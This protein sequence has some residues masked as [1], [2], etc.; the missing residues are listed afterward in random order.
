L[1]SQIPSTREHLQLYN[2]VDIGL[3][4]FP[5]NGTTTTCEALWMGVPVVVLD[6]D[7]HSG[8][9]GVSLLTRVGLTELIADSGADY[10]AKAV[11][12]AQDHQRLAQLRSG[13]R[14]RMQNSPLCD[15]QGFAREVEKSYRKMWQ[16]WCQDN[17]IDEQKHPFSAR[18]AIKKDARKVLISHHWGVSQIPAERFGDDF[19][20]VSHDKHPDFKDSR[21]VKV[22]FGRAYDVADL[23][24]KLPNSW[25]PDLFVAK[26]DAFFNQV[27]VN[28]GQLKCPKVL[29]LGDTQ[30]GEKPLSRMIQ[31]AT[32]E[33]YDI[34]ITDHKRHHLWYYWLAGIDELHWLPG[35]FLNPPDVFLSQKQGS[36]GERVILSQ[37]QIKG[38]P[39]FYRD[40]VVF[41][42]Q[43][44]RFHPRRRRIID[45]LKTQ[46]SNF[47]AH[48]LP[49][50]E[51]FVAYNRA[52]I[53]LNI[54]LNGDL[55]LRVF[56]VIAANGFLLTD[57]LS[58][59]A[60]MDLILEEGKDYVGY[61]GLE[62]L[63]NHISE[64]VKNRD[65]ISQYRRHS[66]DKYLQD[67]SP[68]V[69][70]RRF[71]Q[72][73]DGQIIDNRFMSRSLKR[74]Q[75]NDGIQFSPDRLLIYEMVQ[76]QHQHLESVHILY[77][78]TFDLSSV[79]DVLDL[80]RTH[81]TIF[82]AD[83]K[84]RHHLARYLMKSG[85]NLRVEFSE[86]NKAAGPYDICMTSKLGQPLVRLLAENG[87]LIS[88]D[89]DGTG[90][91][92][93]NNDEFINVK[94]HKE[95]GSNFIVLKK[96]VV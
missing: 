92:C 45:Y 48:Q 79:L 39:E 21:V 73:V 80:P 72:L 54:S 29:I 7:R 41:I 35:L 91:F 71:K 3:D 25:E 51:S 1:L 63:K 17:S 65:L 26:V 15:A 81:V 78:A 27:P 76:E 24:K 18:P 60:G 82:G 16:N 68:Q 10:V 38:N 20:Y 96:D 11:G 90:T 33:K 44:G 47:W 62:D 30:H 66:F 67:L 46:F 28:V 88:S 74:I 8:R 70:G 64:L 22:P 32:A 94:M 5:Y 12:L 84:Y 85:N 75:H 93:G 49:H 95:K 87:V 55:N 42:G 6:G 37:Q 86:F 13:L 61:A 50:Q 36:V 69:M 34:Y 56:E 2:G 59:E 58:E 9:V 77:D 4:P 53:S 89:H 43:S 31:Y 19:Y 52:P 23:I 40:K 83:D 57:I 14:G